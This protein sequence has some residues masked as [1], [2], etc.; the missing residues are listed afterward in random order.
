[1]DRAALI[2]RAGADVPQR[3]VLV[4]GVARGG[5]SMVAGVVREL[6][7]DL[8]A[9]LGPNHE[10]PQF[11]ST[12]VR[13]IRA[14]I[15]RRNAEKDV[16]GW[17]MPHAA[18]QLRRIERNLRNPFVIVV[19]RNTLAVVRSRMA[20]QHIDAQ[21]AFALTLDHQAE[22]A[23]AAR[24]TRAPLMLV[25]YEAALA[26]PDALVEGVARFLHL[27]PEPG[28]RAAAR[29]MVNPRGG[30]RRVTREDWALRSL[31]G[32]GDD[33]LEGMAPLTRRRNVGF[34]AEGGRLVRV[35]A[36]PFMEFA[37]PGPRC[38]LTL[39][40]TGP[41]DAIRIGVDVGRGHSLN[42]VETVRLAEGENRFEIT[43]ERLAAV[44]VFPTFEPLGGA[45]GEAAGGGAAGQEVSNVM[46]VRLFVPAP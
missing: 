2:L 30:Y 20:R 9:N 32:P 33:A 35:N 46:S 14:V 8:G 19:F 28:R 15:A 10:D 36:R 11:L 31:Q 43:H 3:T 12:R 40:R 24:R 38:V 45:A 1:M 17:K 5:T 16:W 37:T 21:T 41:S 18:G 39:R 23:R 26:E 27:E 13:D 6:G 25:D 7:I 29:A 34:K 44:R 22:V 4:T 42:M